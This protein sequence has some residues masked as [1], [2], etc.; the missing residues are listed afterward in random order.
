MKKISIILL[1]IVAFFMTNVSA[2][3]DF[4]GTIKLKTYAEN[5]TDP[6]IISQIQSENE[7][8]VMGSKT[9]IVASSGGVGQMVIYDGNTGV[10]SIIIDLSAMAYGKYLIRDTVDYK[11][12]KFDFN[13][14]END[15]KTI[16]GYECKKVTATMTNLETDDSKTVV[17][18]VTDKLM[19]PSTYKSF[20]Y[21]GLKGYPLYTAIDMENDGNPFTLIQEVQEI[22]PNKKIKA[23][24][25]LLPA[26]WEPI[27]N[28]PDEVKAMLGIGGDDEEDEE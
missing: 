8:T 26:G 21:P 6:N 5:T 13:Y 12:T 25:F 4:A 14:D 24:D 27:E 15:K 17:L 19:N 10:V 1:V 23:V 18:Y 7:T 28:A 2:Q 3:K 20:E 9:K 22:V 11:L 16:A